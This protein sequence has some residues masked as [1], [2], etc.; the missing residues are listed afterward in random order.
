VSEP[1]A[2]QFR[3]ALF[4]EPDTRRDQVRVEA[5]LGAMGDDLDKIAARCGFAA[6]EMDVN[7]AELGGLGED[8]L[9]GGGIEFLGARFEFQRIGAIGSA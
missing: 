1:G 8:A 7:D 9:P 6:G 2:R 5:G 4:V 3:D